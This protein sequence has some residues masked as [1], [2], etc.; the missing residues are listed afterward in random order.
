M[1]NSLK[2]ALKNKILI[3]VTVPLVLPKFQKYRCL[4]LKRGPGSATNPGEETSVVAAFR[5]FLMSDF[6]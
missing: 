4:R 3:D 2:E 1:L 6:E 5:I